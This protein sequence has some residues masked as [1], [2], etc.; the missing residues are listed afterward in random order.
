MEIQ[1]GSIVSIH[2]KLKNEAGQI[3]NA[4]TEGE[5]LVFQHG[6]RA[7]IPGLE[8]E[9][10]G[11]KAGDEFSV[12]IQP[13]DGYGEVNPSLYA[14]LKKEVFSGIENLESGMQFQAQDENGNSQIIRVTSVEGDEITVDR[15][16][17]LAGRTLFFDISIVSVE[18]D[19]A[20]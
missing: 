13:E 1:S 20:E 10:T 18:V 8:K 19:Q 12:E 6:T 9:L 2:Y 11:K 7:V 14:V 15:N 17:P 16:H 4:S 5:P 3:I